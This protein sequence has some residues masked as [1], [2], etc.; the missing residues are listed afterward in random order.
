MIGAFVFACLAVLA[1]LLLLAVVRAWHPQHLNTV[2]GALLA[3]L[4]LLIA[5][6]AALM[7]GGRP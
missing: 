7:L 4:V 5:A 3:Y 2:Q 6:G 1:L